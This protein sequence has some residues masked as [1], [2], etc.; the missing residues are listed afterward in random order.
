MRKSKGC[1]AKPPAERDRCTRTGGH[2]RMGLVEPQNATRH[3]EAIPA[4]GD[5][6]L[7]L[8]RRGSEAA[9]RR[10]VLAHQ[11]RV[12]S[13]ALRLTGQ[14][15]DAEDVA[16]EVFLKL[17]ASLGQVSTAAHLKHW[18]LRTTTHRAIDRN[19]QHARQAQQLTLAAAAVVEPGPE[20]HSD[21]MAAQMVRRLLMELEPD[22]RAVLALRYQEDMDPSEI[23]AVLGFPVNTVK[24]HL[25]RSIERLRAE[26]FGERHGH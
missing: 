18:L 22:A 24:S 16:Q 8:A 14:R 3:E 15:A 20:L 12:F 7:R 2:Q 9:F 6:D 25:R 17:H 5:A 4:P 26:C 21:P 1:G 13:L 11:A 19:R 10:I 23:A